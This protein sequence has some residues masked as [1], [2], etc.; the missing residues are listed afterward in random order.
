MTTK[1][2]TI[3]TR[4]EPAVK[5]AA[6]SLFARIGMSTSTAVNIFLRRAIEEE[7]FPFEVRA[8]RPNIPDMDTLPQ[9]E[10]NRMLDETYEDTLKNGG[11]DVDEAF[12]MLDKKYGFNSHV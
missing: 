10:I 4:T 6:D 7:G 8:S 5:E 3:L 11:I 1:T 9:E 2:A 12:N